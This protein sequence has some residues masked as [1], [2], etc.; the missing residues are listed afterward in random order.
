MAH[1]LCAAARWPGRSRA[2]LRLHDGEDV[3]ESAASAR[4]FR[5]DIDRVGRVAFLVTQPFKEE[6]ASPYEDHRHR[7]QQRAQGRGDRHGARVPG[8]EF[9]RCASWGWT[10]TRPRTPI[11]SKAT[12]IK[13]Q[14]ARA[15]SGGLAVL[16][17]DSGLAV[18]ALD[19]FGVHSALRGRA[20]RRRGEQRQAAC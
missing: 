12:R 18:D 5:T 3:E 2:E 20:V 14:A 8:W 1:I 11:R 10:P 16:A 15:A 4:V 7:Q 17:D 9:A 19:A 6:G 13:A